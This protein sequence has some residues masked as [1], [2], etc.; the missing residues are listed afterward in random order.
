MKKN[1]LTAVIAISILVVGIIALYF[2]AQ[3]GSYDL[4]QEDPFIGSQDAPVVIEEF[5]DFQCPFCAQASVTLKEVLNEFPTQVKLVYRDFPI[6]S[7]QYARTAAKGALCAAQQDKFKDFH[8][9]LFAN[10]E[11]W[12]TQQGG[13]TINRFM[14]DLVDQLELNAEDWQACF[15]SKDASNEVSSDFIE[16]QQRGINSTPSFFINGEQV[17][18]GTPSLFGWIKLIEEELGKKGITPENKT[19]QATEETT[20]E[21]QS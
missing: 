17:T 4:S 13:L 15:G 5:S 10:Q 19:E 18:G 7:H 2:F 6:P 14:Q 3:G 16:G 8:D 21:A 1:T 12:S 11:D 20:E 9:E